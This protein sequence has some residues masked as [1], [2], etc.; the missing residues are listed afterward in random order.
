ML[1]H[2]ACNT[3]P[4]A[5]QHHWAIPSPRASLDCGNHVAAHSGCSASRFR[6]Y[7]DGTLIRSVPS[8]VPGYPQSPMKVFFSVWDASSWA[9]GPRDA[10]IPVDYSKGVRTESIGFFQPVTG[11][12]YDQVSLHELL[13]C[14]PVY[15]G[16]RP[17]ALHSM[18]FREFQNLQFY[19]HLLDITFFV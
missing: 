4:T 1:L 19:D 6:W 8:S 12:Q 2:F 9:T 16:R 11:Y 13:Q 10:R 7:V 17:C 15:H 14:L 18:Q 3:L 5:G